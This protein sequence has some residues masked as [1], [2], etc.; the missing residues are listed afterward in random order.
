MT[1]TTQTI[2]VADLKIGD[3]IVKTRPDFHGLTLTTRYTITADNG[4]AEIAGTVYRQFRGDNAG[5][6]IVATTDHG[7][8]YNLADTVE[9]ERA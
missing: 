6:G 9:V 8:I 7:A 5:N 4:V 3:T 2:P 1:T